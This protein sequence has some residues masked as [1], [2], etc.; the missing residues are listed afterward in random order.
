MKKGFTLIELLVTASIIGV[1]MLVGIVFYTNSR[2][3]AED[4]RKI[5]DMKLLQKALEQ[6]Y[7]DQGQYPD[8]CYTSGPLSADGTIILQ[9]FPSPPDSTSYDNSSCDSTG[10]CYCAE[11]TVADGNSSTNSCDYGG[12]GYYC[13][14]NR[15]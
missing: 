1:L 3:K 14:D 2:G 9:N 10:Y 7:A 11:M 15:Q 12:T 8:P 4:A 6:Y 5:E 13:V